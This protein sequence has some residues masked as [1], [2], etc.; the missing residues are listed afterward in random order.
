M[1][2][3]GFSQLRSN[4][5][6]FYRFGI[7]GK[8][9]SLIHSLNAIINAII[10]LNVTPWIVYK[11][12]A[13]FVNYLAPLSDDDTNFIDLNQVMF[14]KFK[15]TVKIV[16]KLMNCVIASVSSFGAIVFFFPLIKCLMFAESIYDAFMF[17]FHYITLVF[18]I[19][20]MCFDAF[21][22]E[23]LYYVS[24]EH[25]KLKYKR[26]NSFTSAVLKKI[27]LSRLHNSQLEH[28][29]RTIIDEH[30]SLIA[31]VD[32]VNHFIKRAIGDVIYMFVP[33]SAILT[34]I[35]LF[36]HFEH[37][38]MKYVISVIVCTEM[39]ITWLILLHAAN[40][41]T[42][43]MLS[44]TT[45]CSIAARSCATLSLR[46]KMQLLDVLVKLGS[47]HR[48]IVFTCFDF[49]PHTPMSFVDVS[50]NVAILV[51]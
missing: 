51:A 23:A 3:E 21:S 46:N 7:A 40:L 28:F 26:I 8:T 4:H 34:F 24:V 43:V 31:Q 44:H 32:H 36:I 48:P 16:A 11:G 47:D 1:L 27:K 50:R 13:Q 33:F 18:A 10:Y 42:K 2:I 38:H 30:S 41:N 49:Y 6:L 39:M 45:M 20:I 19:V 29:T 37:P 25:V 35:V 5:Y 15:V 22:L 14:D 12:N 17:I 9:I